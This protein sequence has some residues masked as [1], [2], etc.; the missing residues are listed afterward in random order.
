MQSFF[1]IFGERARPGVQIG[2]IAQTKNEINQMSSVVLHS[3]IRQRNRF[4]LNNLI[5][6]FIYEI[7][8]RRVWK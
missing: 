8:D 2:T 6:V 7:T 1:M 4:R 3:S 5:T